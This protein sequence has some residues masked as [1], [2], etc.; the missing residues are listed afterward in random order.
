MICWN[1]YGTKFFTNGIYRAHRYA[2]HKS[3][4]KY[5]TNLQREKSIEKQKE[6]KQKILPQELDWDTNE[7]A[8]AARVFYEKYL[9]AK[10]D[11][12]YLQKK[13]TPEKFRVI[14]SS[15]NNL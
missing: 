10:N 5:T 12:I 14:N 1:G 4:R 9:L 8:K 13:R 7:K 15:Y 6:I 11:A 3:G 2:N